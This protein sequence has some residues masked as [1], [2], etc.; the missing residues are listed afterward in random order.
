MATTLGQNI[1]KLREESNISQRKLAQVIGVDNSNIARW[2][3]ESHKPNAESLYKLAQFFD[4]SIE[5]LMGVA[6]YG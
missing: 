4:V 5:Y 3:S 6:P 1:K 2:E